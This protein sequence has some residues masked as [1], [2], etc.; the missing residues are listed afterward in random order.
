[1]EFT[2]TLDVPDDFP[3]C[4]PGHISIDYKFTLCGD[5]KLTYRPSERMIHD[6]YKALQDGFGFTGGYPVSTGVIRDR[7]T[8]NIYDPNNGT[9]GLEVRIPTSD[10]IAAFTHAHNTLDAFAADPV[11]LAA[12]NPHRRE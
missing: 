10:C 5:I 9:T 11:A 7:L 6:I 12:A 4:D 2:Y 1:M 8:L 3:D